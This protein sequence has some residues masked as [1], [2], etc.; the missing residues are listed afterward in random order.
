MFITVDNK[1][2]KELFEN[3]KRKSEK[4]YGQAV[5]NYTGKQA[6][7]TMTKGKWVAKN[8]FKFKNS[9]TLRRTQKNIRY[10]PPKKVF[11]VYESEAGSVGEIKSSEK[12]AFWLG[13]QEFGEKVEQVKYGQST[14]RNKLLT[15]VVSSK[16][17]PKQVKKVSSSVIEAP[18]TNR[19][20]LII[21]IKKAKRTGKKYVS[22]KWG[23]FQVTAGKFYPGKKNATKIYSFSGK[24]RNLKKMEWLK[25]ATKIIEK[26]YGRYAREAI[27]K[28]LEKFK[29]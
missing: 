16:M 24:S 1:E 23:V 5:K 27:R 13:K 15:R 9:N 2:V 14:L 26:N 25:P 19:T 7:E 28:A 20:G 17:K 3:I 8:R 10:T 11:G 6:F 18:A 29:S 21:A 4:V 12:G 22:N